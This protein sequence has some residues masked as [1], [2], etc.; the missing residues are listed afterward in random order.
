M[1]R[2]YTN[3]N[4]PTQVVAEPRRLGHD[5][6]TSWDAGNANSAV[7]DTEVL[8]FAAAEARILV[9]HNRRHFL[10]LHQNRKADHAGIVAYT[11]DAEFSRQAQR[12]DA[13]V[14]AEPE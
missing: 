7:P 4:V 5:V 10:R 2:F 9:T 11:V 14:A 8:A 1:A 12:I 13:A 3:E 6:M